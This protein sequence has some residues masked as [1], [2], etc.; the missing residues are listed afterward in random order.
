MFTLL[1]FRC[2]M[3]FLVFADLFFGQ[4]ITLCSCEGECCLSGHSGLGTSGE[5]PMAC[6][7]AAT[8]RLWWSRQCKA[9]SAKRWVF[10]TFRH[11][12]RFLEA[13][14]CASLH[15]I[16]SPCHSN[17]KVPQKCRCEVWRGCLRFCAH[18]S[19]PFKGNGDRLKTATQSHPT[20]APLSAEHQFWVWRTFV[21]LGQVVHSWFCRLCFVFFSRMCTRSVNNADFQA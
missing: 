20:N 21:W 17:W 18:W 8:A 4:S 13:L 14:C 19:L 3:M 11:L 1:K 9:Q 15:L 5:P 2:F 12:P 10:G 6:S 7:F 16:L